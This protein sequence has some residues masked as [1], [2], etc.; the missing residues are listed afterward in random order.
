MERILITAPPVLSSCAGEVE[1]CGYA[2]IMGDRPAFGGESP[3][4]TLVGDTI[5]V[6]NTKPHPS[7]TRTR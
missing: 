4:S 7:W 5:S 3:D 2:G 1:G 6:G